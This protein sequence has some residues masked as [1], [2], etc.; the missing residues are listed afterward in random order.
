MIRCINTVSYSVLLNGVP[1]RTFIPS[2]GICQEDPP[3]PYLFILCSEG[4]T[5]LVREVEETGDLKGFG[6]GRGTSVSHILFADDLLLFTLAH[7]SQAAKLKVIFA[8]YEDCSGQTINF[9][10]SNVFFN[11]SSFLLIPE[12]QGCAKYLGLPFMT[13]R[14]KKEIFSYLHNRVWKKLNSWKET[15]LS[16]AAK[17]VL[18]VSVVQTI[19]TYS[20]YVFLLLSSIMGLVRNFRQGTKAVKRNKYCD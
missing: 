3:S 17:E 12:G 18:I 14:S 13:G 1:T 20:M 19:P 8:V 4:F 6:F 7:M 11:I 16:Q 10:K 2:C 9:D 15:T 5:A